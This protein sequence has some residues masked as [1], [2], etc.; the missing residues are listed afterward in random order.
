VQADVT[1]LR[2]DFSVSQP[3]E[4]ASPWPTMQRYDYMVRLRKAT[5]AEMAQLQDSPAASYPQRNAVLAA[6]RQLSG[7]DL[8][9]TT[10]AW[11]KYAATLAP[12]KPGDENQPPGDEKPE[13]RPGDLKPADKEKADLK[14]ADRTTATSPDGKLIARADG[15]AV[16]IL[17]A[18]TMQRVART[19]AHTAKVAAVAF[20][21]DGSVV[22]SGG[23]D[24]AVRI[25][26]AAT[27]K[28][29]CICR[30]TAGVAGIT[31]SA[32]GTTLT[33]VGTDQS[34]ATWDV[35]TGKQVA[36]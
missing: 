21:P 25:C 17:D 12:T 32:D 14:P 7:R 19:A 23:P 2:Q 22:A 4:N 8:G 30:G 26:D 33:V 29:L 6:L 31:F 11:Q 16:N 36:K 24:M 3:V 27:G 35:A 20:S 28:Q 10:E 9:P 5:D 18:Q 1:F 34:T 15:N 13:A